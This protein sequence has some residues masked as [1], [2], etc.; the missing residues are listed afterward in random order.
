MKQKP[1]YLWDIGKRIVKPGGLRAWDC[2]K[3][4]AI[5]FRIPVADTEKGPASEDPA[6]F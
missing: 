4:P 3:R 5:P 2:V 1:R 6:R